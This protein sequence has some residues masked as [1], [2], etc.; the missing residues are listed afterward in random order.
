MTKLVSMRD[1]PEG[2]QIIDARDKRRQGGSG[3]A[4]GK[5]LTAAVRAAE[6]AREDARAFRRMADESAARSHLYESLARRWLWVC[7]ACAGVCAVCAF[8]LLAEV[9]RM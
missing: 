2:R 6:A 4:A 9:L 5:G 7:V 3:K 1:M 8:C